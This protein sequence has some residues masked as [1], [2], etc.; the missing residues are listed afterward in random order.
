MMRLWTINENEEILRLVTKKGI[1]VVPGE[2]SVWVVALKIG[3]NVSAKENQYW[4]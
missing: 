4:N 1:C 2:R 3:Y